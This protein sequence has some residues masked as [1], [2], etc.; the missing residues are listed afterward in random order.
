MEGSIAMNPDLTF[1]LMEVLMLIATLKYARETRD[2]NRE[3]L[4]QM[5]LKEARKK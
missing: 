4:K 3:M 1:R 5:M 2:V